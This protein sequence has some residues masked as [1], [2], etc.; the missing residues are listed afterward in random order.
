M[1]KML[2]AG[3]KCTFLSDRKAETEAGRKKKNA[4]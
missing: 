4:S 1:N 2:E 3:G